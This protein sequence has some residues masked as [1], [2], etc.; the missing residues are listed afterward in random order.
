[1]SE[2][3]L[4]IKQIVDYPRCRIYRQF[5]QTLIADRNIRT[6][7]GCSGL[8]YFTVLCAYANFRTSYRRLEGISYTIYPGEWI[9][10]LGE[11]AQWFRCR[12]KGQTLDILFML[13]EAHLIQYTVLG[14]GRL[15]RYRIMDW[16]RHN[17]VLDYNCPCQKDAGFFFL[18]VSTAAELVSMGKCSDMDILLDLWISAVYNDQRVQGSFSGPVAYFR[19][20]SGC[21]LVSYANL[22]QRW[23]ISKATVGRVLKKLAKQG[24]ISLLTFPGRHGTAIYLQ[25]YLS[26]MFQVSDVMVDKEEVALSLNIRLTPQESETAAVE[27]PADSVSAQPVIVSEPA[28]DQIAQRVLQILALQEIS[29]GV[30]PRC[31]YQLYPLSDDG[32][33]MLEGGP[34]VQ[35]RFRMEVLCPS[36]RPVYVFELSTRAVDA[37]EKGGRA[38]G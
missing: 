28:E 6:N 25:N 1:M 26:T 19:D 36:G 12:T 23:G 9:C 22:A 4:D 38:H 21:P 29:C 30:C 27:Q 5:I 8:F 10:S 37:Q 2:Y 3:Q 34:T 14:R 31:S 32:E 13:Q 20:G 11:M 15:V 18:P 16:R 24:H 33:G 7:N 17:T 35:R